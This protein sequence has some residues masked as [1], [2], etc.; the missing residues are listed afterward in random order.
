MDLR[1]RGA[2]RW[3]TVGAGQ[4]GRHFLLIYFRYTDSHRNKKAIALGPF[5]EA[6]TRGL[7][8]IQAREKAGAL[9]RLYRDGIKDLHEHLKRELEAAERARRAEDEA[10]RRIV[11]ESQRSTL[12]R[13]R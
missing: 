10:A 8:L 7:T 13:I 11:E 1:R 5:D 12:R 3:R 9:S 2:R 4:D 6:G